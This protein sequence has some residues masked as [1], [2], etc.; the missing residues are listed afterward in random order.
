ME[1]LIL[2]TVG[3]APV[4]KKRMRRKDANL[5][6]EIAEA[7]LCSNDPQLSRQEWESSKLW[8]WSPRMRLSEFGS[9]SQSNDDL[10]SLGLFAMP[11]GRCTNHT[12]CLCCY[13]EM[14]HLNTFPL[15]NLF[16]YIKDG[17]QVSWTGG[18]TGI[19]F[20]LVLENLSVDYKSFKCCSWLQRGQIKPFVRCPN[21]ACSKTLIR[22]MMHRGQ[23]GR[24][25]WINNCS[26]NVRLSMRPRFHDF[27][28]KNKQT[29]KTFSPTL[30][31]TASSSWH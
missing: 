15:L 18:D 12:C 10:P 28:L 29:T 22:I 6:Y 17:D 3:S 31:T 2:C 26:S 4:V 11:V 30:T 13:D 24:I 19:E 1:C 27:Y 20:I 9:T 14:V 8:A 7:V 21:M 23:Q 16:F 25:A 5:K